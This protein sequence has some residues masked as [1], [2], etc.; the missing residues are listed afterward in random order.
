MKKLISTIS[1]LC[2]L[3]CMASTPQTRIMHQDNFPK[4]HT[5]ES[6]VCFKTRVKAADAP[7][8][9]E[10]DRPTH[11]VKIK[12]IRGALERGV[13]IS[14]YDETG[15][16]ILD[17]DEGF[18]E[19]ESTGIITANL[20]EGTLDIVVEFSK[21]YI[22]WEVGYFVNRGLSY[23]FIEDV[24]VNGNTPQLVA[25]ANEC[26]ML[27]LTFVMADGNPIEFGTQRWNGTEMEPATEGN[28]PA[29]STEHC[30]YNSKYGKTG[31]HVWSS[32]VP[33]YYTGFGLDP[34]DDNPMS[35]WIPSCNKV[36]DRWSFIFRVNT[37]T[38]ELQ[39]GYIAASLNTASEPVSV[40]LADYN[41]FDWNFAETGFKGIEYDFGIAFGDYDTIMEGGQ[42]VIINKPLDMYTAVVNSAKGVDNLNLIAQTKCALEIDDSDPEWPEFLGILEPKSNIDSSGRHYQ[43]ASYLFTV[44]PWTDDMKYNEYLPEYT[45]GGAY[46]N[47]TQSELAMKFG[48]STPF[49]T[50]SLWR[51][52]D[53][54]T[55][56]INY[57]SLSE[58][59]IDLAGTYR[60]DAGSGATY[61]DNVQS[62]VYF[63]D[64]LVKDKDTDLEDFEHSWDVATEGLGKMK[65]VLTDA[66][67]FTIDGLR[68]VN[69]TEVCYDQSLESWEPPTVTSLLFRNGDGKVTNRIESR[70]N[71]AMEMY[72]GST[73]WHQYWYFHPYAE[74][75]MLKGTMEIGYD[76]TAMVEY[77][78]TGSEN[79]QPLAMA[80][81]VS[82]RSPAYGNHYSA[83]LSQIST[84]SDNGW[85][86]LRITLTTPAGNSQRQTLS[87]AFNIAD[88]A[89]V[90]TAS[91]SNRDDAHVSYFDLQGRPLTRPSSGQIVIRVS[92]SGASKIRF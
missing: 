56:A 29:G 50:T 68:P 35:Y 32:S 1:F 87:P 73:K 42:W 20:P 75:Y 53:Y 71:A 31:S 2:A 55:G 70:E 28:C 7:V 91:L 61:W 26:K 82:E 69:T 8:K 12:V 49:M 23:Y 90:D 38:T 78:P 85:Y 15:Y 21:M 43:P 81:E 45:Y 30:F 60:Y 67:D 66:P 10:S 80:E 4:A 3:G 13:S 64:K 58:Q 34:E 86:D 37:Y 77:A 36:S 52:Q 65:Y 46:A 51:G 88:M 59:V 74:R 24:E 11:P 63:N 89:G 27:P 33:T 14:Y 25:D 57:F 84:S 54:D 16:N 47:Y 17:M 22:N 40:T 62:E 83:N 48:D 41:K 6:P 79:W 72:A 18:T 44:K 19:D 76:V 9:A 39:G 5:Q 92:E